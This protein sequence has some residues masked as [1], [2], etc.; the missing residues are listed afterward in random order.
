MKPSIYDPIRDPIRDPTLDPT[1][2]PRLVP[3][4]PRLGRH[5][6][7]AAAAALSRPSRPAASSPYIA[8]ALVPILG[9]VNDS[10]IRDPNGIRAKW[11]AAGGAHKHGY[12]KY[13][14]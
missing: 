10:A 6:Q 2:G 8:D 3:L 5:P 13:C 7:E 1:L 4:G 9:P 12:A 11:S 14:Q